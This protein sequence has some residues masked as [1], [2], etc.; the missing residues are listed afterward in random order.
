MSIFQTWLRSVVDFRL[1]RRSTSRGRSSV[2]AWVRSCNRRSASLCTLS[3]W[4]MM[5]GWWFG[6]F[7]QILGIIIPIDLYFSEGVK[8]PTRWDMMGRAFSLWRKIMKFI[9][10][11]RYSSIERNHVLRFAFA[12][13]R[14]VWTVATKGMLVVDEFLG[15]APFAISILDDQVHALRIRSFWTWWTNQN[16]MP[17][18]FFL[19]LK[20]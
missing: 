6:I 16:L 1:H 14:W 15:P 11:E 18:H 4:D 20:A 12:L 17:A 10:L 13:W 9:S 7:F 3:W 2:S 19:C 8:P 5:A